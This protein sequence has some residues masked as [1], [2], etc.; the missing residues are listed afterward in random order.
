MC[1]NSWYICRILLCVSVKFVCS[2]HVVQLI[3]SCL[4]F[5]LH[6]LSILASLSQVFLVWSLLPAGAC[7]LPCHVHIKPTHEGWPLLCLH[8]ESF[9]IYWTWHL[10]SHAWCLFVLPLVLALIL[11]TPSCLLL[12]PLLVLY[13]NTSQSCVPEIHHWRYVTLLP[14]P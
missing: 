6:F 4:V 5:S 9:F 7:C 11:I 8:S 1:W 3:H 2:P 14:V 10:T 13:L 12:A